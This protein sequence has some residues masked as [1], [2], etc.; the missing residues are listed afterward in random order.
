MLAARDQAIF[1]LFL[2]SF[3]RLNELAELQVEDIDR[4]PDKKKFKKALGVYSSLTQSGG[5]SGSIRQGKEGSR[6]GRRVLFQV[7]FGCIRTNARDNDFRD[8][9]LR[10]VAPS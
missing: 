3:I 8:Y 2:E 6:H 10:Q 9:Y 7:C 4:W 5:D 1:S